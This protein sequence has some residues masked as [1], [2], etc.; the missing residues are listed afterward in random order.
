MAA[1]GGRSNSA[2]NL[3][4]KIKSPQVTAQ[5]VRQLLNDG[6]ASEDSKQK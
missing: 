4:D 6:V 3:S 2:D 1:L 5:K